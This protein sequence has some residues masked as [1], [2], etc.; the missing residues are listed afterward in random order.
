MAL[1]KEQLAERNGYIGASEAAG[2]LGMSRWTT[3]LQI[4]AEKLGQ[5]E[6]PDLSKNT[7]V[8]VGTAL[9][10]TVAK[11]FAEDTGKKVRRNNRT[12]YHSK[13]PFI[14][15]H[16]DREIVGENAIL[17]CKTASAYKA[18]EWENNQIPQEYLIQCHHELAVSGADKCYI[19]CLV[20]NSDFI[21]QEIARDEK[22]INSIIEKEV[23]FWKEFV[24]KK[25][26]PMTISHQDSDILFQ[27]FPKAED[28]EIELTD[29]ADALAES[30]E[31]LTADMLTCEEQIDKAKNTLKA[32]LKENTTGKA[33][34]HIITW[35]LQG[36]KGIDTKRLQDE[37]PE[38]YTAYVKD[39]SFKK[40]AIKRIEES[41]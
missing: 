9:E 21:W 13:Y 38:I 16:L 36:R 18:K 34:K 17:E 35:K 41:K 32:M 6:R 37:K 3:P 30:I 1:T 28:T 2:V 26:M 23:Y 33:R 15:C 12:L 11:F 14:A 40:L 4:W 19:A 29:E 5:V 25:Q 22:I 10:D 27:L 7:A 20:G 8:R 39:T 24:E 31:A